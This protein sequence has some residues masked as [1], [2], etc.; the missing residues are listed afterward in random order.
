MMR[1]FFCLMIFVCLG[2]PAQAAYVFNQPVNFH[3]QGALLSL[4]L[5]SGAV[6]PQTN[7]VYCLAQ[8][9][10]LQHVQLAYQYGLDYVYT[11]ST[12]GGSLTRIHGGSA[13]VHNFWG[14]YGLYAGVHREQTAPGSGQSY[15]LANS[16]FNLYGL[17]LLLGEDGE[18]VRVAGFELPKSTVLYMGCRRTYFDSYTYPKT[19]D[20][21]LFQL[22]AGAHA[23]G[24]DVALGLGDFY[25]EINLELSEFGY[26]SA[27][28]LFAFHLGFTLDM[29]GPTKEE[30]IKRWATKI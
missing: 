9:T 2:R 22:V 7:A 25:S 15:V 6:V 16:S 18:V 27:D 12:L 20:N 1:G 26:G 10:I 5:G 30:K 13:G 8:T 14:R 24:G 17:A 28:N 3:N 23:V 4:G 21:S 19:G 29:F 11:D